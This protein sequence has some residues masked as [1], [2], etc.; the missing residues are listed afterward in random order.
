MTRI[1]FADTQENVEEIKKFQNFQILEIEGMFT[2]F[3][4]ADEYDRSPAM[5]QLERYLDFSRRVEEVR[6][7]NS[8]ASLF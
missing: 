4:R 2:H 5:V 1:G 3:A 6:S 7:G 8:S